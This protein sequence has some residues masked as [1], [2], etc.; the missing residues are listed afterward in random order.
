MTVISQLRFEYSGPIGTTSVIAE[1][2]MTTMSPTAAAVSKIKP[3]MKL[4]EVRATECGHQNESYYKP[5]YNLKMVLWK[6]LVED[7][8]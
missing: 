6:C 8:V 4:T 3:N 2:Q 1:E 7:K 5:Y